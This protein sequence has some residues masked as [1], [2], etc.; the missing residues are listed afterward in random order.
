MEIDFQVVHGLLLIHGIQVL[1]H[2]MYGLS[3]HVLHDG[4]YQVIQ[5][6]KQ[7]MMLWMH[8]LIENEWQ[9]LYYFLL[10][11]AASTIM[12]MSAVW[13]PTVATGPLLR[14]MPFTPTASTSIRRTSALRASTAVRTG[15]L[16]AVSG[17]P[18]LL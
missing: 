6:G 1:L 15:F 13:G 16:F 14:A 17:I 7:Y 8:E 18:Q 12:P 4:M 11:V 2:L 9:K 3:D 5:N 10:L